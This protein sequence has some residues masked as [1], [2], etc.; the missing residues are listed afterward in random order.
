MN[1]TGQW[2]AMAVLARMARPVAMV[3]TDTIGAAGG[4]L[5]G[6]ARQDTTRT[7][8]DLVG[9]CERCEQQG[10]T[11]T[12]AGVYTRRKPRVRPAPC[13]PFSKEL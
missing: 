9:G 3:C 5:A 6:T 8:V 4:P 2:G 13:L 12:M 10:D 7:G 1:R 11:K